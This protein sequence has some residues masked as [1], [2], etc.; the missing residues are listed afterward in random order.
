MNRWFIHL[1]AAYCSLLVHERGT[2]FW[3]LRTLSHSS[4]RF[5]PFVT[6]KG[7]VHEMIKSENG[8][9]LPTP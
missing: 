8:I 4:H 1:K 6:Q 9:P 5:G 2:A 7:I 3:V